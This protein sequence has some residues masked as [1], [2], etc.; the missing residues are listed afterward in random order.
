MRWTWGEL[1]EAVGAWEG[2]VGAICDRQ[3][4]EGFVKEDGE[5]WEEPL[6]EEAMQGLKISRFARAFLVR[7][8]RP[9]GM[10]FVA[11][12]VGIFDGRSLREVYEAEAENSSR[13][14]FTL[15]LEMQEQ[16]EEEWASLIL[17]EVE[18]VPEDV[19][20]HTDLNINAFDRPWGFGK[21]T[22]A[23]QAGLYTDLGD[24]DGDLVR[25]ICPSGRTSSC[26]FTGRCS[27]GPSRS[28]RLAEL[29]NHWPSLVEDGVWAVCEDG[30]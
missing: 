4:P 24:L 26:E 10:R 2:L 28:P 17:P 27:W 14:S 19:G 16:E 25:L 9:R 6:R 11:P 15:G 30:C 12:G 5:N 13:R 22:V 21:F 20:Q 23:R 18:S 1:E 29:L 3:R 8:K 7:A